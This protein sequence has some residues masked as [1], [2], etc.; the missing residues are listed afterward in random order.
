LAGSTSVETGGAG[1]SSGVSI[2]ISRRTTLPLGRMRVRVARRKIGSRQLT[3]TPAPTSVMPSTTRRN[4]ITC[5]PTRARESVFITGKSL[6]VREV[7]VDQIV[8]H[9]ATRL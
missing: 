3:A 9:K 2:R 5:S 1:A 7:D 4:D 6:S 8:A